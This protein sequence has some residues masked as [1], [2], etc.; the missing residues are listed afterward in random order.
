MEARR[1]TKGNIIQTA[2]PRTQ[3]RTRVSLGLYGVRE[4]A[5]RDK[6]ARFTALLH[7]VTVELLRDSFYRLKRE[8]AC[9]RVLTLRP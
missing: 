7:H 8:A 5:R 1:P 9:Q 4:V 3:G 2:M 6:R